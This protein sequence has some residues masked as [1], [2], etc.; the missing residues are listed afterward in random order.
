MISFD[1]FYKRK[2]FFSLLNRKQLEYLNQK[3]KNLMVDLIQNGLNGI[4]I[5]YEI[6]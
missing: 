4:F 6:Y 5:N 2:L 1:L 3:M